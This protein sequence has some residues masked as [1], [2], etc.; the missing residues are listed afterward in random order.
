MTITFYNLPKYLAAVGANVNDL[1]TITNDLESWEF[2]QS[3]PQKVCQNIINTTYPFCDIFTLAQALDISPGV[4]SNPDY[5]SSD[6]GY[7]TFYIDKETGRV[8]RYPI[9]AKSRRIDA[10]PPLLK[11]IQRRLASAFTVF[12]AHPAN[13]AFIQNKSIKDALEVLK[14]SQTIIHVDLKDFFESHSEVYLNKKIGKLIYNEEAL[15]DNQWKFIRAITR[16]ITLKHSLPQG[17]PTSPIIS[18]V[19]NYEMDAKLADTANTHGL[20]YVRYADD[21]FFGG[22]ISADAALDF[23]E[24]LPEMVQPF[25]INHSKVG[26]MTDSVRPIPTGVIIKIAPKRIAPSQSAKI[27]AEC[28]QA[29]NDQTAELIVSDY[30]LTIKTKIL[31][32]TTVTDATTL[33]TPFITWLTTRYPALNAHCK[34]R[35]YHLAKTKAVLGAH[36]YNGEIKFSRKQYNN[37]R[38]QA[39]LIGM[40]A[41]FKY[42]SKVLSPELD[43]LRSVYVENSV[44]EVARAINGVHM[45]PVTSDV[46][47]KRNLFYKPLSYRQYRGKVNW[48]NQIQA[49]KAAKLKSVELKFF[50]STL[51]KICGFLESTEVIQEEVINSIIEQAVE[52]YEQ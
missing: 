7:K 30:K 32:D 37:M 50:K 51:R 41:A 5:I 18:V 22:N 26:V 39:M 1:C 29:L 28:R 4:L 23:I 21:L 52:Y 48:I 46:N 6:F 2:S 9:F 13:F 3:N 45:Y 14:E 20:S 16:W 19:V 34:L 38:L 35:I 44:Q 17:A 12:P 25:R 10:P 8:S 36:I 43:G 47:H 33:L 31:R 42:A 11:E 27:L 15:E 24:S 49:E 40:Q